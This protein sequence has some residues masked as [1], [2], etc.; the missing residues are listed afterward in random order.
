MERN[1]KTKFLLFIEPKKEQKS[2]MPVEDEN[3]QLL[4]V[5]LADGKLGISN[6]GDIGAKEATFKEGDRWK[7]FH[8]ADDGIHSGNYDILLANGMI[9][10]SL[11]VY[12]MMYY[13]EAIPMNDW[14]K[15]KELQRFYGRTENKIDPHKKGF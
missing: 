4:R 5:A 1:D 11:C 2:A 6:Y 9:T 7:G 13:R 10:N 14:D 8:I 15:I 12:Y 3:T